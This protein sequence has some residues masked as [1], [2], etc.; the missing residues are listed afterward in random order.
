[1][2]NKALFIT[3]VGTILIVVAGGYGYSKMR[4]DV[5]ESGVYD[6]FAQCLTNKGV[7][8]YGAFWCSHCQNQK[9]MFGSSAEYLPYIECS[10]PDG[11]SL[12]DACTEAKITSFP[13]WQLPDGTRREGEAP[14]ALLA[15]QTGCELPNIVN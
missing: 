1:M 6:S 10:K 3:V 13:T 5:P 11:R 14:L 9:K 2:S 4:G 12:T 8:F 15:E 7:K